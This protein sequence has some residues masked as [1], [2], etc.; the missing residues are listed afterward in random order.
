MVVRPKEQGATIQFLQPGE[1]LVSPTFQ[2]EVKIDSPKTIVLDSDDVDIPF[3][4]IEFSDVTLLPGRFT[5][6]IG[7]TRFDVMQN[8]IHV[9]DDIYDWQRE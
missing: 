9:N 8:R 3:V 1:G 2:L 5:I 6:L 7:D 4:T